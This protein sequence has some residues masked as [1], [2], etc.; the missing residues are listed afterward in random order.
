MK[1]M[2]IKSAVHCGVV[3]LTIIEAATPLFAAET[4]PLTVESA[5]LRLIQQV[6][7]PARAQ[8]VLASIHA[9][10]GDTVEE[11]Q[12]LAQVDDVEAQLLRS[13]AEIEL[14]LNQEKVGKDIA[15]R[16]AQR[17]LAFNR[18]EYARLQRA[19][20]EIPR[21]VSTSELE[22]LRFRA[23]KAELELEQAQQARRLDQLTVELK[24][25][26]LE[27]SSHNV[28]VRR[29]LAPIN[30]M[31]V[32]VLKQP[33]EWVEPGDKVLRIVRTDRLRV[34]G[35]IHSRELPPNLRGADVSIVMEL[36]GKGQMTFPGKIVFVS[37]E[38]SPVN[39]QVR[40]WAEVDNR[41][42]LLNPGLRPKMTIHPTTNGERTKTAQHTPQP[43]AE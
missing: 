8:G 33:G 3:W 31:V 19:A 16:S 21:S 28:E 32:E 13:R 17:A 39:G 7:V 14:R 27:L 6:E 20:K 41:E 24:D 34:E 2:R 26:E 10:E 4:E 1:N 22:E 37:P 23:D 43:V 12:L 38:I 25:K 36:P 40:V 29:I 42:G 11:G 15:I 30:G 18:A 5:L 35:L 9:V